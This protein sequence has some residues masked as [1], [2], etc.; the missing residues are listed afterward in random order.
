MA[1]I[2]W[3][4]EGLLKALRRIRGPR[5]V[6]LRALPF[7]RHYTDSRWGTPTKIPIVVFVDLFR[8]GRVRREIEDLKRLLPSAVFILY[9]S[10]SEFADF[11]ET[12]SRDQA[13]VFQHYFLLKKPTRRR[14]VASHFD[15]ALRDMLDEA[16]ALTLRKVAAYPRFGSAF[17]S[18]SHDDQV[19]ARWLE[20]RLSEYGIDVARRE[21]DECRRPHQHKT[22]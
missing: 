6:I 15:K 9:A 5:E 3:P 4:E 19:F 14:S 11:M 18:C 10:A 8:P 12:L 7:L 2:I 17:I 21:E 16:E 20:R 1:G 13:Q 22:C